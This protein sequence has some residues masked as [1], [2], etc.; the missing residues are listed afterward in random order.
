MIVCKQCGHRNDDDDGFCGSCGGFLEFVGERADPDPPPAAPTPPPPAADSVSRPG[1]AT[2]IKRAVTGDEQLASNGSETGGGAGGPSGTP[3]RSRPP[4]ERPGPARAPDTGASAGVGRA[5]PQ[6]RATRPTPSSPSADIAPAGL[7]APTAEEVARRRAA[8][9]VARTAPEPAPAAPPPRPPTAP[10]LRARADAPPE[11]APTRPVV[12]AQP[13]AQRPG[14]DHERPRPAP[15]ETAPRGPRPGE[16]VCDA[17]GEGNDHDRRF[18]RRCGNPLVAAPVATGAPWWRRLFQRRPDEA[19]PAGARPMRAAGAGGEGGRRAG[20]AARRAGGGLLGGYAGLRKIVALLAVIGIGVGFA[21]PSVRTTVSDGVSDG[22]ARV[23]RLI[24][25][26]Y[27]KVNPAEGGVA[28]NAATDEHP[29]SLL[30]DGAR[31]TFWSAP[32]GAENVIIAIVFAEPTD[33]DRLGITPGAQDSARPELFLSQPRPRDLL[34]ALVGDDGQA[35]TKQI[36][37]GDNPDFQTFGIER[38]DVRQV[39]I[40]V[41]GCYPSPSGGQECSIAELELFR[42]N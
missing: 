11:P 21:L 36:T 37:V 8:A 18:C 38:D 28:A 41:Q 20:R 27:E 31:N 6:D 39:Q 16:L 2:R 14:V 34:V 29:A 32:A 24:N 30:V 19:L 10:P 1:I 13:E 4:A 12:P 7:A 9:L 23:R 3:D 5:T 17:C 35:V 33:I 26:Q 15:R 22:V 25:P 42:K 40:V